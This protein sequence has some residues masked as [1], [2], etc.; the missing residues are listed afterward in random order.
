MSNSV[1]PSVILEPVVMTSLD[2]KKNRGNDD[3]QSNISSGN[4]PL[5][6]Y[7]NNNSFINENGKVILKTLKCKT[8][9]KKCATTNSY[10]RHLKTHDTSRP[11]TCNKCDKPFKTSQV[12]LDHLKRHYNDRRHRCTLCGQQFYVK[13]NLTDHMRSH[14]GEKPFKCSICERAFGTKATLRQHQ[15]VSVLYTRCSNILCPTSRSL[16]SKYNDNEIYCLKLFIVV[17]TISIILNGFNLN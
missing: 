10:N 3:Y 15:I 12:L 2:K 14:T 7:K 17:Y 6:V 13:A 5:R 4:V 8:C 11:Y 9:N 1:S 16:L